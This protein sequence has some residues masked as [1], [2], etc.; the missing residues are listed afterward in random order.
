VVSITYKIRAFRP[1]KGAFFND[2]FHQIHVKSSHS[3]ESTEG[4]GCGDCDWN[5]SIVRRIVLV[6]R[7]QE[8]GRVCRTRAEHSSGGAKQVSK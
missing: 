4:W 3:A 6:E 5:F 8:F 1:F 7:G 2:V